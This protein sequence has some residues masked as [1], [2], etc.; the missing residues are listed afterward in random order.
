LILGSTVVLRPPVVEGSLILRELPVMVGL[1]LVLPFMLLNGI[2]SR[3]EAMLLLL[4]AAGFTYLVARSSPPGPDKLAAVEADAEAVGAPA[5]ETPLRLFA[6]TLLGVI[7]LIVGGQVFVTGASGLAL[8]FGISQRIV[9][10]TVAAVGTSAPELA[11][12]IVAALRGHGAIAIGN[13][14]GSNIFNVVFVLGAVAA[15]QPVPGTLTAYGLD[16]AV[17]FLMSALSLWFLRG[18]RL[19][20]RGEGVLLVLLYLVY[21]AVL[22]RL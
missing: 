22:I 17:L 3:Q 7:V 21:L 4:G 8:T 6:I 11:A 20:R 5:G 12:S 15:I 13:V 16:L 10:L 2:V 1:T 19:F 14:V 18:T 9:G